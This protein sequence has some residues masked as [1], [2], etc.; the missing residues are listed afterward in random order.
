MSKGNSPVM[1]MTS[2][3]SPVLTMR[4]RQDVEIGKNETL[5][6]QWWQKVHL[7]APQVVLENLLC[8]MGNLLIYA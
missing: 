8:I 2:D 4:G 5:F 6:E 7:L 1:M 3:R